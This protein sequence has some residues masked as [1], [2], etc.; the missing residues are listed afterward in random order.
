MKKPRNWQPEFVL[1][2]CKDRK[3]RVA[4]L[5]WLTISSAWGK[6][7][8]LLQYLASIAIQYI[9][10]RHPQLLS[11][12]CQIKSTKLKIWL[13]MADSNKPIGMIYLNRHKFKFW[14]NG[15]ILLKQEG[16]NFGISLVWIKVVKG[17]ERE[18]EKRGFSFVLQRNH[19]FTAAIDLHALRKIL[20]NLEK[21]LIDFFLV[22]SR[23]R[24][25]G[26]SNLGWSWV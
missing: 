18:R 21:R 23:E 5:P 3:C 17:R 19:R 14:L 15:D 6:K 7:M 16:W 10:Q 4:V 1:G 22:S 25:I 11:N 2:R 9:S 8:P 24:S 13:F 26:I 20:P 12:R